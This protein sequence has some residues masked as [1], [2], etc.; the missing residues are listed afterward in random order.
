MKKR[1]KRK[2]KKKN[3]NNKWARVPENE[4]LMNFDFFTNKPAPKRYTDSKEPTEGPDW[5]IFK[6]ETYQHLASRSRKGGWA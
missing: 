1:K 4:I 3:D 2:K 5:L 6:R